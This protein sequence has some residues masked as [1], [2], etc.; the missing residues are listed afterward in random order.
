M[1]NETAVTTALTVLR[2][3]RQKKKNEP[4]RLRKTGVLTLDVI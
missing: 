3:L 4:K 1:S 2:M